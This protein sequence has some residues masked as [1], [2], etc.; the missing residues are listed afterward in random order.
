MK[1]NLLLPKAA[2]DLVTSDPIAV[3][4]FQQ[5]H[6]NGGKIRDW[7][8]RGHALPAMA[9]AAPYVQPANY[10]LQIPT[11]TGSTITVE[12]YLNAPSRIT[13]AISDIT[14][15]QFIM[16]KIFTN[17]GG[18]D[19]GALIYDFPT[20][21]D[22]Y[23]NRDYERVEP[24]GEF[25]IISSDFPTPLIATVEKWGAK[26]FI[27]DEARR[28]NN[29]IR[30]S[31]EIRKMSNTITRKVNQRAI[32]AV[33]AAIAANGGQSNYIGHN[34]T[35]VVTGGASQTNNPNWPA[36]DFAAVQLM[37][38][39]LELGVQ[40]DLWILNPADF[41]NLSLVYGA[42]LAAVLNSFNISIYVSRRVTA[43]TAYV[44]AQGQVGEY[45]L[46]QQLATET[47]REIKTQRTW[48]QSS[49]SFLMA[50]TNPFAIV[51]VTGLQG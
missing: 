33:T 46:E 28:R 51:Q 4:A 16:D 19:G 26:T 17:G 7:L 49:T 8:Q 3:A 44:I 37:A 23:L 32:D 22:L 41:N 30:F 12:Q 39:N 18:V 2:R 40:Y 50:V 45:R 48:V 34:W 9:G 35:T 42:T 5:F 47:W 15:E 20:Y 24:G 14:R 27:T 38:D 36:A 29:P 6:A 13:R 43:G 31:Q 21:N 25:P 11:I 10:P 1:T